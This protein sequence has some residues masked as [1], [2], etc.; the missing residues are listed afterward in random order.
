MSV[1]PFGESVHL[2]AAVVNASLASIC[3]SGAALQW[4]KIGRLRRERHAGQGTDLLSLGQFS[5]SFTGALVAFVFGY[6]A[7]AF[8]H[9]LV[10]PR[11]ASAAVYLAIIWEIRSDRKSTVPS[12]CA[13]ASMGMLLAAV[14]GMFARERF[15]AVGHPLSQMAMIAV[16]CML[17]A[18]YGHQIRIIRR[19]GSTG[20]LSREM[21]QFIVA[22]DLSG[23]ALALAIGINSAWP[24]VVVS[25]VSLCTKVWILWLFRWVR[26]S[27]R[28]GL[29]RAEPASVTR[30]RSH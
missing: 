12:I 13:L 9:A 16:A 20:A 7:P 10:W 29:L 8:E 26:V 3:F 22:M 6:T 5:S 14:A 2:A 27:P 18:G 15:A 1:Y 28:A 21:N 30:H 24:L 19:S 11:L 17:A 4:V 25:G 23:L